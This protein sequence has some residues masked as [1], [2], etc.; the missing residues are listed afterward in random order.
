MHLA[1]KVVS[2]NNVGL[3]QPVSKTTEMSVESK[4]FTLDLGTMAEILRK[5]T[6]G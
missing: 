4:H 3:Y 2:V 5:M 1:F 6:T